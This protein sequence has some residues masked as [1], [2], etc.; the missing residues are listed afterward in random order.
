MTYDP[1]ELLIR[2]HDAINAL[3]F[4]AIEAF[5]VDNATY[6]SGKIGAVEGKAVILS[7]FRRYFDEY[8]DQ[9]ARDSLVETVSRNAA[10]AVWHLE[11]TSTITGERLVRDGEETITFDADGRILKV[12]VTDYATV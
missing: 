4:A 5:F 2:Y 6:S 11:A 7:G 12:E 9:V 1:A 10:R 8:P 3:D